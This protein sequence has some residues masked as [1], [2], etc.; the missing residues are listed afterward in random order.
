MNHPLNLLIVMGPI[1]QGGAEW[2]LYDTLLRLDKTR[3]RPV[4][5]S[6]QFSSYQELAIER[7]DRNIQEKFASLGI[8]IYHID[9]HARYSISNLRSLYR[10]IR[11]ERIDVVHANLFAGET[12]G[13][14][15]AILCGVP[16][17]TQKTGTPFKSRKSFNV[18]ADWLLN[19]R[20]DRIVVVSREIQRTLQRYQRLDSGKFSVIYPGIDPDSWK[21]AEGGDIERM[22]REL[23]LEGRC[24]ITAVGRL[25]PRK[26]HRF[27]MDAMP[28]IVERVPHAKLLI[29]GDGP[30]R[31]ELEQRA[32]KLG[33]EQ[34]VSLLGGRSDVRELLSLTDVFALPSLGEGS[35]VVLMEAA[36]VGVASVATDVGGV[37]EVVEDGVTGLI[38]PP[39]SSEALALA[40]TALLEDRKRTSAMALA[41][42]DRAHRLFTVERM[43]RATEREYLQAVGSRC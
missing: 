19:L 12:W 13:R 21:R 30:L 1:A 36:F 34:H 9:G 35:P 26:A 14:A 40:I 11:R 7:G 16:V 8:P 43:V 28:A 31:K 5:V 38:V 27:L 15:A 39:G 18:L 33:L 6:V 23:G 3:F 41:A 2:Q 20:T 37:S 4:V 32:A 42:Q 24:V 17:V 22:R 10:I 25:S 29:A